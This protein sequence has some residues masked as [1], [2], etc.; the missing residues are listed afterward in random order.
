MKLLIVLATAGFY[1]MLLF[2][3]GP[4]APTVAV[5]TSQEQSSKVQP[6]EL[7]LSK[8]SQSD[9]Y[10]EVAFSHTTHSTKNYSI[11]GK[12]VI[13]CAECHHTDQPK[14]ALKPPLIT[15]ERD[16]VLTAAVLDDPKSPPVK[17]CRACHLQAGDDSKP[18][19]VVTYPGKTAPEKLNNEV[20]YHNNCNTCHDTAIK[21]R[22]DLK[23]KIPG[24]ND[25]A[26]CHKPLE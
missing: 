16:V 7:L 10:G 13:G 14:A 15:S 6:K 17:T 20:A 21:V 12:S 3:A 2:I 11:D 5:S 24:T 8:D 23:G 22:A 26:K 19:P 9:K 4:P 25:C 1:L 18:L